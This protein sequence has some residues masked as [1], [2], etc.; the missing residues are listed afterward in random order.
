MEFII[1]GC[2]S[3]L[4]VP[5][6]DGHFG[7]CN[8][9]NKKNYRTRCSALLKTKTENVLFDTSPDLRTQLLNNKI[10]RI[11]KVLYSHLHADQTHGINELRVFYLINRKKIPV[12]ADKKTQR[13]LLRSFSYC[14]KTKENGYPSILYLNNIKKKFF[15]KDGKRNISIKSI[16]V[17]HGDINSI[18][19]IVDNKLAYI[20]DA[21]K[22]YKKDLKHFKKLKYLI[23]DC[24]RIKE[25]PSH[26]N[27]N[28][29]LDLVK[30]LS[31]NKTILTNLHSDLDYDKLKKILPSKIVP[32]FDGLKIN[33]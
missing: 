24:L 33:L 2:G 27:L 15:I 3:S 16:K 18:C 31:P 5:R 20:S 25:H 32:A 28:D 12:F 8:P 4:G 30:E 23:I 9:G 1:L 21:N 11:D 10:K 6:L 29:C 26:F 19:Y 14:F 13:Y 17:Q 22:I 7:N